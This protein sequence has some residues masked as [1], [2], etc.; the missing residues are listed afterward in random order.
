[1][2]RQVVDRREFLALSLAG[3]LAPWAHAHA[4]GQPQKS[5]Y[6][7]DVRLLYGALIYH[8]EGTLSETIDR[9]AGR[10]DVTIAGEGDGIANRVESTGTLRQGRWAPVRTRSSFRVKGRESR[11][12]V[13]YDHARRSVEYHFKGETFFLRR[14]RVADDVVSVPEGLLVDDS[15]SA[16]LNYAEQRWPPQPDGS[17]LTHVIR[18]KRADNEGIDD[19]QKHYRAELVPFRLQVTVDAET[20]KPVAKIDLTRFSSWATQDQPAL[21]TFGADRRPEHMS[22]SMI[23]GTSV[24]IRLKPA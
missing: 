6:G 20:R 16:T 22:L 15:I 21:I 9:A 1:M 19:V 17:F 11:S 2:S 5:P 3:L 12:D 8:V 10:Y 7:V 23:L 18:R 13:T 14:L 24:Q 4:A